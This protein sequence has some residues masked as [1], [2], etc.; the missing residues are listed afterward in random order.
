[1]KKKNTPNFIITTFQNKSE[2]EDPKIYQK[3]SHL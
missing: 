3:Q 2:K 1:M